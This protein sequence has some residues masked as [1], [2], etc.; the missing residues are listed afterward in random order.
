MISYTAIYCFTIE[1]DI[2][3]PTKEPYTVLTKPSVYLRYMYLIL[4]NQLE[5]SLTPYI[6]ISQI[7][8]AD[9]LLVSVYVQ[10]YV[11]VFIVYTE[12]T[13]TILSL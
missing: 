11:C 1:S 12:N 10:W 4:Y 7:V 6:S 2:A 13:V 5:I 3:I 9:T 8:T